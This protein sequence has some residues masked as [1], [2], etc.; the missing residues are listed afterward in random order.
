MWAEFLDRGSGA[1]D[2]MAGDPSRRAETLG[3]G[4]GIGPQ[5][6]RFDQEN[7]CMLISQ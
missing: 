5:S 1:T 2:F 3:E 6:H 4:G 7:G